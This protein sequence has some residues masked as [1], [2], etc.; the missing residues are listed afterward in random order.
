MSTAKTQSAFSPKKKRESARTGWWVGERAFGQFVHALLKLVIS[1]AEVGTLSPKRGDQ[2]SPLCQSAIFD[3]PIV[4]KVRSESTV[5]SS[6][7]QFQLCC[8]V[9]EKTATALQSQDRVCV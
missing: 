9:T 1:S 3:S 7:F 4:L 8:T 6:R 2:I 5:V